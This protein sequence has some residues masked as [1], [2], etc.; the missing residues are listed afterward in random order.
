MSMLPLPMCHR[1]GL[2]ARSREPATSR[3][4][5]LV[6]T[7]I[8]FGASLWLLASVATFAHAQA[9]RGDLDRPYGPVLAMAQSG[10]TLYLGGEF[11]HVGPRTS[12]VVTLSTTTGL[13][14]ED[15][16]FLGR[17]QASIS[18][19]AGGWYVVGDFRSPVES[20]VRHLLHI[21]ADGSLGSLS[22][23]TDGNISA[24]AL[25]GSTLFVGGGFN[26]I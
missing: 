18:D 5:F 14:V 25:H 10:N 20:Y 23:N 4:A 26:S 15:S 19:G 2:A 22:P 13:L 6:T 21:R 16:G 17:S 9:L 1:G 24:L 7:L 11:D 8:A 12:N 3:R